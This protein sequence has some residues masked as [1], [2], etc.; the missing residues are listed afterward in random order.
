MMNVALRRVLEIAG[1]LV[2][3]NLAGAALN[4]TAKVIEAKVKKPKKD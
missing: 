2:V 3:G 1:G 4:K